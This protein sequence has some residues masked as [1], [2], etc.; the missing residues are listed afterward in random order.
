MR[1]VPAHFEGSAAYGA[2]PPVTF[3]FLDLIPYHYSDG[4]CGNCPKR[5]A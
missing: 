4:P 2:A 3:S 5:L 1:G